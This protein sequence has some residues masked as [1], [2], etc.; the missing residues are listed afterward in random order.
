MT[1]VYSDPTTGRST[2]EQLGDKAHGGIDRLSSGAHDA[3]DRAAGAAAVAAD[4]FGAR[5]K[6]LVAA[7][8]EWMNATRGYVREHPFAALGVALAA[9]YL[10]SRITAR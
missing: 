3:V 1:S 4:R 5:S 9:G 2:V 10:L 7:R 8:D 6:E